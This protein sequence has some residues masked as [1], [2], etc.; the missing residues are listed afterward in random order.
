[1][2]ALRVLVVVDVAVAAAISAE[3]ERD[4]GVEVVAC[5]ST[6]AQATTLLSRLWPDVVLLDLEL[7]ASH[8]L[9]LLA[10]LLEQRIAPVVVLSS[11]AAAASELA[12]RAVALGAADVIEKLPAARGGGLARLPERL[13]AA[14]RARVSLPARSPSLRTTSTPS[15]GA[16]SLRTTSTLPAGAPS[17]RT[18]S[19]PSA[20]APSLRTTST[21]PAGAPSLRA[22]SPRP[23]PSLQPRAA[24]IAIGASTGG[25]LA[26]A[27][28][29]RRL[30]A[31]APPLLIVQHMLSEFTREF[32]ARLDAE[33]AMSVREAQDGESIRPG[34]ALIAPGGFHLRLTRGQRGALCVGLGDDAPVAR[35]RPSVDVLFQSCARVAGA[36]AFGVVL[37]GMGQDGAAGMLELRN[38]GAA[39]IAQDEASSAVFGMPRAAISCG[40]AERVLPL[41][42]IALAIMSAARARS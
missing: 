30:P 16:P 1:V 6:P 20:G 31:E 23:W 25:T 13:R 40:A 33:S 41:S 21:L 3:L 42:E 34:C 4:A 12:L 27:E 28:L 36:S 5:A 10:Q 2:Q 22:S 19:T 8:G 11:F 7:A 15:A 26:L 37:T 35:L 24:V 18:T 32:A 39:T 29:L 9:S 17:P 14:A 38:V